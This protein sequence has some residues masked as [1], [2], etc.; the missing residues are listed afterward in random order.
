M[1]PARRT[2]ALLA[3]L[4]L[5]AAL[6]GCDSPA[7][8]DIPLSA[9]VSADERER[10]TKAHNE[11][12]K[13]SREKDPAKA[14]ILYERALAQ[15]SEYAPA[16]NNLGVTLMEQERYL[17][18]AEAFERAT[19]L[20]PNDP[21]P[22]Y[23]HGLLW[24]RRAYLSEALPFFL[25]ANNQDPNYLPALRA[26]IQTEIRLRE[27]SIETLGRIKRALL[28]ETNP[29]WQRFFELQRIKI[30]SELGTRGT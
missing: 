13:A 10:L 24:F 23:N 27:V 28:L 26:A 3:G 6:T 7:K 14:Q 9:S 25:K 16:W 2:T 5:A 19:D 29:D 12:K 20:A 15:Y 1:N 4:L 30:E 22:L 21:R 17:E 8:R 18:A 11:A